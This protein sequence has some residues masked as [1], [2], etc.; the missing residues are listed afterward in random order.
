MGSKWSERICPQQRRTRYGT[1]S[2]RYGSLELHSPYD[3][4]LAPR[5]IQH[6]PCRNCSSRIQLNTA[7][8]TNERH[9][10]KTTTTTPADKQRNRHTHDANDAID[11]I[12]A[13]DATNTTDTIHATYATGATKTSDAILATGA[14]NISNFTYTS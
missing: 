11:T 2:S 10:Y 6:S 5:R 9:Y 13:T 12:N 1:S 14:I 7:T 8:A 4:R 3:G